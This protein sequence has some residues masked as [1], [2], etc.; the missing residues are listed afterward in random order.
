MQG[1]VAKD[2]SMN[3]KLMACVLGKVAMASDA[4][5]HKVLDVLSDSKLGGLFSEDDEKYLTLAALSRKLGVC[6]S[7]LWRWRVPCSGVVG[8]RG[9][10][11]YLL[12][13]AKAFMHEMSLRRAVEDQKR[14]V[15]KRDRANAVSREKRTRVRLSKLIGGLHG[16]I[17]HK[18][19]H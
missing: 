14:R 5:L 2:V 8:N 6:V 11:R 1:G 17:D 19:E 12:S 15:A 7:T 9:R 3:R 13:E 10:K 4:Q 18:A 16:I